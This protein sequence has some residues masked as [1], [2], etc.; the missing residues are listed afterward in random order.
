MKSHFFTIPLLIVTLALTG[1]SC[2]ISSDDFDEQWNASNPNL[3]NLNITQYQE[4]SLPFTVTG[5]ARG[6]WFFEANLPIRVEDRDGNVLQQTYATAQGEWM[7]T[8][9]V[10]FR[11]EPINPENLTANQGFIIIAKDN[12]SGLPEHNEESRYLVL[13]DHENM[14]VKAFFINNA[15]DPQRLDC[16]AV[17]AVDRVVPKTVATARAALEQLFLGPT[18]EEKNRGYIS[19]INP[20]VTISALTIANGEAHVTLS[21]KLQENVGGSCLVTSIRAQIEQTLKQFPTVQTV[22]ISVVGYDDA[23]ILQP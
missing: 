6:N 9:F 14:T 1:L 3:R 2:R 11:S 22:R 20:G 23:E 21:R 7:T 12:P 15:A 13:F 19:A 4:I 8:D 10:P 17:E 5:E 18:G 16:S